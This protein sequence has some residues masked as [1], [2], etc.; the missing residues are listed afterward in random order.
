[1]AD[2]KSEIAQA[3]PF[4]SIEEEAILNL[5]RTSDCMQRVFQ[6]RTR[7]WGLT[8]TQYCAEPDRRDL[9]VLRSA[10]A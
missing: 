6:E 4:S 1:M 10:G 8:S 3:A 9:R 2:L 7:G 5:M